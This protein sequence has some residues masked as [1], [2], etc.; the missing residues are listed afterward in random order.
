MLLKVMLKTQYVS[1]L[2]IG[3][4]IASFLKFANLLPVALIGTA[5][6]MVEYYNTKEKSSTLHKISVEGDDYN[7]G[8]RKVLTKS[9]ITKM[10]IYII[11]I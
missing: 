7:E 2:I 8:I 9:D 5:L 4:V 6:A 1:Y 11:S 3:F 10:E